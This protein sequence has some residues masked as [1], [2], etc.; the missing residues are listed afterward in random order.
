MDALIDLAV[1]RARVRAELE[2]FRDRCLPPLITPGRGEADD[3][4]EHWQERVGRLLDALEAK[5]DLLDDLVDPLQEAGT[6]RYALGDR[7]IHW[8]I[9]VFLPLYSD[10]HFLVPI[11][12]RLGPG[13][14]PD[15]SLWEALRAHLP[16]IE[17]WFLDQDPAHSTQWNLLCTLVPTIATLDPAFAWHALDRG[18]WRTRVLNDPNLS[19]TLRT[20][21]LRTIDGLL[22]R[23]VNNA[24]L[25]T[26]AALANNHFEEIEPYLDHPDLQGSYTGLMPGYVFGVLIQKVRVLGRRGR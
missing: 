14:A 4:L 16:E 15:Q 23:V 21:R 18:T 5:T 9:E 19:Y 12:E 8:Q 2:C 20:S 24:I 11:L 17:A 10:P 3:P 26:F 7:R 13:L 6:P 1:E 22:S 25:H